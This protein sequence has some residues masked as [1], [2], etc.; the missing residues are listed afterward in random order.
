MGLVSAKV[1]N[2]KI[3]TTTKDAV[4]KSTYVERAAANQWR[5]PAYINKFQVFL[6]YHIINRKE[7]ENLD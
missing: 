1:C 7:K 6:R 4:I 2:C 5:A 3:L